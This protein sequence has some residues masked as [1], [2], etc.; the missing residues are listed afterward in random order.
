MLNEIGADFAVIKSLS[1]AAE[2]VVDVGKYRAISLL[3][4]ELVEEAEAAC[5]RVQI[6]AM[7]S[8]IGDL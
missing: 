7:A 2:G 3:D 6:H 1:Q 5:K 4:D 8:F